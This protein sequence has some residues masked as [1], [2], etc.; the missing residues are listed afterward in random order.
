[1]VRWSVIKKKQV[2]YIKL[3]SYS[4]NNL[5]FGD[6]IVVIICFFQGSGRRKVAGSEA[7]VYSIQ[8]TEMYGSNPNFLI[9]FREFVDLMSFIVKH[10]CTMKSSQKS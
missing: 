2:P 3:G 8:R 10:I 4:A 5:A 9:F 6:L 7:H 1:M